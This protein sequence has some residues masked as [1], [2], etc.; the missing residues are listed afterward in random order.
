MSDRHP[1]VIFF[2]SLPTVP[3]CCHVGSITSLADLFQSSYNFVLEKGR[4]W[5]HAECCV[6]AASTQPSGMIYS[7]VK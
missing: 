2:S 3:Q 7:A 1:G 6:S 4:H 5:K